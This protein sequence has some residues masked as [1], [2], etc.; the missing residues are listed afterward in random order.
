MAATGEVRKCRLLVVDTPP[1][2]SFEHVM[3]ELEEVFGPTVTPERQRISMRFGDSRAAWERQSFSSSTQRWLFVPDDAKAWYRDVIEGPHE[4]AGGNGPRTPPE[5]IDAAASLLIDDPTLPTLLL[6][7]EIRLGHDAGALDRRELYMAKWSFQHWLRSRIHGERA[8]VF[9]EPV[10]VAH[11]SCILPEDYETVQDRIQLLQRQRAVGESETSLSD[12]GKGIAERLPFGIRDV[13]NERCSHFLAYENSHTSMGEWGFMTGPGR[14]SWLIQTFSPRGEDQHPPFHVHVAPEDLNFFALEMPGAFY[15]LD[16][17][18][19]VLP[20]VAERWLLQWVTAARSLEADVGR[21]LQ[22]MDDA[23]PENTVKVLQRD[24]S[25]ALA[26]NAS[27]GYARQVVHRRIAAG[28]TRLASGEITG[29]VEI[30]GPRWVDW[31]QP[32]SRVLVRLGLDL[33]ELLSECEEVQSR[34]DA[35]LEAA[36]TTMRV[37]AQIHLASQQEKTA[38]VM[39]VLTWMI[40]AFTMIATVAVFLR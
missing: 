34:L 9:W 24:A 19:F 15:H 25:K 12:L 11:F 2:E 28:V 4:K 14:R 10:T 30:A 37:T 38:R 16:A 21:L 36:T 7:L 3:G 20:L 13:G 39:K 23:S 33:R 5:C 22:L 35:D 40:L 1:R 29:A 32:E 26:A 18:Q 31:N 8:T 17:E 6:V 27:L